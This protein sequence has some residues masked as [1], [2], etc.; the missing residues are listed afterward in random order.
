MKD[1]GE[2]TRARSTALSDRFARL[3]LTFG[4]AAAAHGSY[5]LV[6]FMRSERINEISMVVVAVC[7]VGTL[8]FGV[9][10]FHFRSA[11]RSDCGTN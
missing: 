7:V 1:L 9:L 2:G 8:T 5:Q 10:A 11:A 3:A 6:R 4:L